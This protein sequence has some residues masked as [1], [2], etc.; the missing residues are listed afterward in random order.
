MKPKQI[1]LHAQNSKLNPIDK[2]GRKKKWTGRQNLPN[3][4]LAIPVGGL[5]SPPRFI[6]SYLFLPSYDS[7]P[8]YS[9]PALSTMEVKVLVF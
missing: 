8:I 1:A 9:P 2:A 4:F 3:L 7:A 6:H 5:I